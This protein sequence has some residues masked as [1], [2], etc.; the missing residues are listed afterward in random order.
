MMYFQTLPHTHNDTATVGINAPV[1][2]S[3]KQSL[4]QS[5]PNAIQEFDGSD[6]ESTLTWLDQVELVAERTGFD[7]LEVGI[8]KLKGLTLGDISTIHKE[9]GLSWY[10]FGQHL[11]EQYSDVPYTPDAMFTYSKISQQ[12]NESTAQYLVRARVLLECIHHTF[13]LAD[14]SMDNLSLV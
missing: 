14:I 2:F 9:E 8:S 4:A 11:I 3:A 1:S 12:D 13:K 10:K 5:T 7:P 6:R